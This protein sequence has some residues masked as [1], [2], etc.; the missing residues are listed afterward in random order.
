[1]RRVR[2]VDRYLSSVVIAIR[3]VARGVKGTASTVAGVVETLPVDVY[4]EV[5]PPCLRGYNFKR[6]GTPLTA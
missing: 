5:S 2:I 4:V 3:V 6:A 1:M